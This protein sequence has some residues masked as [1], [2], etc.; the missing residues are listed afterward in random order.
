MYN[1]NSEIPRFRNKRIS[2]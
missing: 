1:V 2:H